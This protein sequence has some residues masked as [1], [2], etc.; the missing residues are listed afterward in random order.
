[1]TIATPSPEKLL[2]AGCGERMQVLVRADRM[3]DEWYCPKH[4][5]QE[6]YLVIGK[7]I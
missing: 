2:H 3:Y 6:R 4:P 1:M 7:R 5:G